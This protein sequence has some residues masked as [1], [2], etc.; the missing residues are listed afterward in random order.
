MRYCIFIIL[1]LKVLFANAQLESNIWYFGVNAGITFS[2]NPPSALTNGA[3]VA[4]EGCAT[5]CNSAGSLLFYT[6]GITVFNS[7]HQVMDNGTG[8]FG[9]PSSTMSAVILQKPGSQNIYYIFTVDAENLNGY[10]FRYSTVDMNMNGG[11]GKVISK[12]L[13]LL[14]PSAEKITVAKHSNGNSW[15]VITH[16]VFNNNFYAYHVTSA[17]INTS[18]VVSPVGSYQ[19]VGYTMIGYMKISPNNQ[20]L[21][22]AKWF[23]GSLELFDFDNSTGIVSNALSLATNEDFYGVEFSPDN[24]KLYATLFNARIILQYD[25]LSPNIAASRDTIGYGQFASGA[26]Q[27]GLDQKIYYTDMDNDSLGVINN[28]NDFNC[29]YVANAIYLG[30]KTCKIGLPNFIPSMMVN[31]CAP[32][33]SFYASDTSI[34]E[35]M[36]IVFTNTSPQAIVTSQQWLI[37]GQL[38][39]TSFHSQYVFPNSGVFVI[40]MIAYKDTCSD[41]ATLNV[42]VGFTMHFTINPV[43]CN[44]TSFSVGNNVYNISGI[45]SD[46]L[47]SVLGCDSIVTTNLTVSPPLQTMIDTVICSGQSFQVGSHIYTTPGTYS[48]F[49]VTSLGC[50]SLVNTVL[51]IQSYP[52][53]DLG[54]D[55]TICEGV[56][57]ALQAGYPDAVYAWQDGSSQ[58]TCNVL[59]AGV[60]WVDVSVNGCST[61][62]SINISLMPCEA[63]I[64]LPN[65]I[66]P[67][68]DGFNDVFVPIQLEYINKLNTQ[69]FNRWGRLLFT[70]ELLQIEWDGTC[71]G[72]DV[73]DG[74]YFYVSN[75]TD[76]RGQEHSLSGTVTVMR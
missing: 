27:T 66:T 49:F 19:D 75:Y 71:Q 16:G 11:L 3:M 7:I 47:T 40:T 73:A 25:M 72:K 36:Q 60:Y 76:V 12:N 4:G 63:V 74:V 5:I 22:Y 44:G 45:Y 39:D 67:N 1:S 43:I 9:H 59:D 37:D 14:T 2:T 53:F 50:D 21:A 29:N 13:L 41:T 34:C 46:T 70:S 58:M 51:D 20:K 10:G 18:A 38:F 15:W 52:V 54:K 64:E 30:G 48:D 8:L 62:D 61:R 26:L 57:F 68:S 17:G 28:P 24:S 23:G 55:T 65:I 35:G 42:Y 31:S 69:I 6:D 33:A 32:D 56:S